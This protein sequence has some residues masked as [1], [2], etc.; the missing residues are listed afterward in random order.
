MSETPRTKR[1]DIQHCTNCPFLVHVDKDDR[2][3][4]VN[5]PLDMVAIPE[6]CPL[7]DAV[8]NRLSLEEYADRV[9]R[10]M[11]TKSA[12]YRSGFRSALNLLA[13]LKV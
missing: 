4:Q 1:V 8:N 2:C 3:A 12:D 6:W 11:A 7:P 9:R 10:E 5:A 13:K